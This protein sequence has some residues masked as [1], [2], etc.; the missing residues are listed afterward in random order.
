MQGWQ[1]AA[2]VTLLA[3]PCFCPGGSPSPA[4]TLCHLEGGAVRGQEWGAATSSDL[5]YDEVLTPQPS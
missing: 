1:V 3:C 5:G 4:Q 2:Q